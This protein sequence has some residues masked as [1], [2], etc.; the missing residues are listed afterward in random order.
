MNKTEPKSA[1]STSKKKEHLWFEELSMT[2]A[3]SKAKA[4][5]VVIIPIGS[6]EEHGDH[7]S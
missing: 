5:N 3:E 1:D 7:L 2:E 4:G 6:V